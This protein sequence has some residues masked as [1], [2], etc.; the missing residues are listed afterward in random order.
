MRRMTG[1]GAHSRTINRPNWQPARRT[2]RDGSTRLRQ[3]ALVS[4]PE[5]AYAKTG[6]GSIGYQ[7]VGAGPPD[8]LLPAGH[9]F[10]S[11]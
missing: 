4:A 9:P 5:A 7:V 11:I 6:G 10:P 1:Q 8:V 2:A 3:T